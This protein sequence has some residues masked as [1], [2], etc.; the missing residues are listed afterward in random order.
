M[1]NKRISKKARTIVI[2]IVVG[3]ALIFGSLFVH[4]RNTINELKREVQIQTETTEQ[5][6]NYTETKVDTRT[7]ET[8]FNELQKI[9]VLNGK[10][11]IKHTYNYNRDSILGLDSNYKLGGTADFYYSFAV[12]LNSAKIINANKDNITI[13]VDKPYLDEN[14]CHRIANS[15]YRMNDECDANLLSNKKD[16]ET[17]TRH[18]EDTFDKKGTANIK[19][20]YSKDDKKV[21]ELNNDTKKIIKDLLVTLGY[22]QNVKIVFND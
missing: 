6:L 7:I 4:Q 11:N 14:T 13:S 15:F 16:A 18:W 2:G 5:R 8:K 21:K 1:L 19:D 3:A 9:E 10:I 12:N 17:C 22:D 20:L